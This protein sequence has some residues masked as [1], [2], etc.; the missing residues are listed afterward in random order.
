MVYQLSSYFRHVHGKGAA[1][2]AG[3]AGKRAKLADEET[4][5]A[6]NDISSLSMSFLMVQVVRFAL[7]GIL[8]NEEGLEFPEL[9]HTGQQIGMI[10]GA[11][12]VFAALSA[13]LCAAAASFKVEEKEEGGPE[14]KAAVLKVVEEKGGLL[15]TEQTP[16]GEEAEEAASCKMRFLTTMINTFA[17]SYA[18]CFLFG[19]RWL[20]VK[21]PIFSIETIMG[22][23]ILAMAV[24]GFALVFV[25][26]L[27][28]IDDTMVD[29]GGSE[30]AKVAPMAIATAINALSILVGFSWEHSFDGGV[31]AVAGQ[32]SNPIMTKFVL[33]VIV[34]VMMVPAWRRYI[35]VR[36]ISLDQIKVERTKKKKAK[37]KNDKKSISDPTRAANDAELTKLLD[38]EKAVRE[39]AKNYPSA[40]SGLPELEARI[41]ALRVR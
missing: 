1:A 8:P 3:K 30:N 27:D 19:T 16:K 22:R 5:E 20:F 36:A 38:E 11:G 4:E 40:G 10:Y 29:M 6:E 13:G 28:V 34:F 17:M 41:A 15:Q 33:A 12:L 21:Y 23:V 37:K 35:L 24:S 39:F 14:E 25:F 26:C 18:W 2:A 32:T 7:T 31:A 9:P